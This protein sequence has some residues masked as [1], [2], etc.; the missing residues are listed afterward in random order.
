[1]PPPAR[2]LLARASPLVLARI[3]SA[4]ITFVIPLVLVRVFA[5]AEYG[6]Y[7]Q[8]LLVSQTVY[9]LLPMGV[10]QSLYYF[11]PR[12]SSPRPYLSQALLFLAVAG[13]AGAGLLALGGGLLAGLLHNP[14]LASAAPLLAVYTAALLGAAPLEV[15]WTARGRTGI[16]AACYL[17]SDLIKALAMTAPALLGLGLEGVLKGLAAFAVLRLLATWISHW[18]GKGPAIERAALRAQLGYA[19]PVGGAV[20]LLVPQQALHPY[21]VSAGLDVAAFAVYAVGTFQAPIFDMLYAPTSEMLMVRL[22]ELERAGKLSEGVAV[23]REA[24]HKLALFFVPACAFLIAFAPE[25][26]SALFTDKYRVA[27]PVFRVSALGG[28][29]ACLP[30]DGAL[31][32]RG[33]T[34]HLLLASAVKIAATVPLALWGVARFGMMGGVGSWLAAELIGKSTLALRLPRA[35]STPAGRLLP[36]AG[37]ARA[38]AAAAVATGATLVVRAAVPDVPHAFV[39]LFGLGAVFGLAALATLVAV[40]DVR[41]P[42]AS[43]L[44]W[45]DRWRAWRLAL[46]TPRADRR[47]AR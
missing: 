5:P 27:V 15:A 21:L 41:R 4:G 23:F 8:L 35:L 36:W 22:A 18:R 39:R 3:A 11:V 28:L 38:A 19:L 47:I 9:Y 2:T 16:A 7:K 30:V 31:R 42:S 12:A 17:G 25:V 6:T 44:M 34:R 33:E 14:A 13:L 20:A 26:V 29:L 1:M 40:G 10:A 24:V 46:W 32:A 37:L 43:W 45:L